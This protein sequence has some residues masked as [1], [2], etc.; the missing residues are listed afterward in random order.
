MASGCLCSASQWLGMWSTWEQWSR[1]HG[2]APYIK[3]ARGASFFFAMG[4][5]GAFQGAL[6]PG[7]KAT[8]MQG[9]VFSIIVPLFNTAV[10]PYL[11]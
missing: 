4:N 2:Q 8:V 7:N 11:T 1:L 9:K 10:I 3:K 6:N 5:I